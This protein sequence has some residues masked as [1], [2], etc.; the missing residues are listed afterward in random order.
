MFNKKTFSLKGSMKICF[1]LFFITGVLPVFAQV[2]INNSNP[3]SSAILDIKATD[4]GLLVPRMNTVDRNTIINPAES[5]IV[6]DTDF[7]MFFFFKNGGWFII[8]PWVA[9]VVDDVSATI[10]NYVL[11]SGNVGIGK[12]E[13]S[14]KLEVDGSIKNS[15]DIIST[16][17]L[18]TGNISA[19]GD[20]EITGDATV[21]GDIA[22]TGT[23]TASKVYGEGTVPV[24]TI[25]MWNGSTPPAGWALCDGQG[26]TPDLRGR[27]IVGYDTRKEDYNA[28][29]NKAGAAAVELTEEQMPAHSHTYTDRYFTDGTAAGGNR[30]D[31]G[32]SAETLYGEDTGVAGGV[33]IAGKPE[34]RNREGKPCEPG[35]TTGCNPFYDD[36]IEEAVPARYE[37]QAH[38]NRPPY[39][40]L[41]YIIKL[42]Y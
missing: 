17:D 7:E 23:V 9:Q 37:I 11:L 5:L 1:L 34:V 28:I 33:Y 8:N 40:T 3:D 25:V 2:G 6:Y 31:K 21:G 32:G 27:F 14:E 30:A 16:G 12:A 41:A 29:G 36:I 39:Y 13:P 38:E 4:K 19:S 35:Q 24:G 26:E 10:D 42:A 18:T 20:T 15:G 22:A